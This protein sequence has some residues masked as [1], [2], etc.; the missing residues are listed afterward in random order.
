MMTRI[1]VN[2]VK[3]QCELLPGGDIRVLGN[4]WLRAAY[5]ASDLKRVPR[6]NAM[7]KACLHVV[8]KL[9]LSAM[10]SFDT[11][12]KCTPGPSKGYQT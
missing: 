5:V 6:E 11:Y 3:R 7:R 8:R 1:D 10:L 12:C 2:Q 9:H 4:Q